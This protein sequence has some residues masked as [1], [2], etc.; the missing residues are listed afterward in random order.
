[1][2]WTMHPWVPQSVKVPGHPRGA[3]QLSI[4]CSSVWKW[5][6]FI[7]DPPG[8]GTLS[9]CRLA[10]GN[11][12]RTG[13]QNPLRS[14]K[15]LL[16]WFNPFFSPTFAPFGFPDC[17]NSGTANMAP[18]RHSCDGDKEHSSGWGCIPGAAMLQHHRGSDGT[19]TLLLLPALTPGGYGLLPLGRAAVGG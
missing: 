3:P 14:Q 13:P 10:L 5:F 9:T 11:L 18:S 4:S 17:G 2:A 6:C 15:E 1:M 16:E 12:G 19:R 8:T 7:P